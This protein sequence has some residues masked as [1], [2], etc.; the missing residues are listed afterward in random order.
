MSDDED[1]EDPCE[2]GA[3]SQS[4]QMGARAEK[5][6]GLLTQ[7]FLKVLQEA[8]DGVVDLNV[9]ADRLKVKQKRRIYDITNVLEGVGLIEKRSK[10]SV[11]WKG[12]AVGKLGELNPAA[13][14]TL[15]NLKLELTDL[16]REERRLDSCMK[17]LSQSVKNV[18]DFLDK[19]QLY[20]VG[21]V[22]V[23]KHYAGCTMFLMKA[24]PGTEIELVPPLVDDP[25]ELPFK[26]NVINE[27]FPTQVFMLRDPE[28]DRRD[29]LFLED[30]DK[31][32]E[33]T[34]AGEEKNIVNMEPPTRAHMEDD[35][36]DVQETGPGCS[37]AD[38]PFG[39]PEHLF[40]RLSPPP[41][42]DDYSMR[43]DHNMTLVE[44]YGR[45]R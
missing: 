26:F 27:E 1:I 43:T 24:E 39:S 6:L 34:R 28:R 16:E 45:Q 2:A 36:M 35:H 18:T 8:K 44:L 33:L 13:T 38:G 23:A 37:S 30:D 31:P 12:G 29:L 25:G 14:E 17:W 7:K 4:L 9:A 40:V 21:D 3:Y 42:E 20:F 11:Q 41:S 19:K 10:N 5:S 22:E 32:P 15:F